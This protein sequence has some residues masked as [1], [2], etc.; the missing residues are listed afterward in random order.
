MPTFGADPDAPDKGWEERKGPTTKRASNKVFELVKYFGYHRGMRMSQRFCHE[1]KEILARHFSRRLASGY[2][3][4]DLR[5]MVD[6]FYS[7][8]YAS[9]EYPALMFC[10]TD[11][12]ED[13]SSDSTLLV[14]DPVIQWL[15]D[16]MPSDGP[17][18]DAREV[19]KAV[20]LNCDESLLRYPDLVA[21]IIRMDDPEPHLSDRL[22]ALENLLSWN[23][24]GFS[25]GGAGH[26]HDSLASI[27]LPKELA[28][29]MRSPK[30]LRRKCDT[31]REAVA[32]LPVSGS[33]EN[34]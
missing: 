33:K 9:S 16:G 22:A 23:L 19:R 10:K 3:P 4:E 7:S 12:Q 24:D 14:S 18:T 1:D 13:L 27:A 8:S 28:S 6:K 20:L 29:K 30:M 15:V 26:L 11:V 2:S 21:D 17:F 25:V 34:W 5:N 31:V 32:S